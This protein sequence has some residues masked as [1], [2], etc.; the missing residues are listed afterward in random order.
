MELSTSQNI[1][2]HT[3]RFRA[4]RAVEALGIDAE[5]MSMGASTGGR[6]ID[7]KIFIMPGCDEHPGFKDWIEQC[8]RTK[9][10]PGAEE[11]MYFL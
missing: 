7:G 3:S 9:F 10:R 4:K 6:R 2:I 11:Q 8:I 1:L 5:P